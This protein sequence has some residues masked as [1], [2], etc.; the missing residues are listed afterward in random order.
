MNNQRILLFDLGKVIIDFDHMIAVRKIQS[1]CHVDERTIFNL[2]FDSQLTDRF[3]R[4]SIS[5]HDFFLEVKRLLNAEI[6]YEEFVPIWNEIFQPHPGSLELLQVLKDMYPLYMVSNINELHFSYLQAAFPE[7]FRY[8]CYIFL[9]YEVGFRKPGRKIYEHTIDY[10][11]VP[12]GQIIYTD[13]RPELVQAAR[14]LGIDGFVFESIESFL[15][16]LRMRGI[17]L[18]E[19]ADNK[20]RLPH[21]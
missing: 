19:T 14:A 16:E 4:G 10:I 9:S 8:F 1:L 7:Y 2:F 12:P 15:K 17:I 3:E 18:T 6:S 20:I 11:K 5:S 21:P 13:D